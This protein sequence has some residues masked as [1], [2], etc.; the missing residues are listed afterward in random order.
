MQHIEQ[1]PEF[2]HNKAWGWKQGDIYYAEAHYLPGAGA[3]AT[4]AAEEAAG[5]VD[6]AR[7]WLRSLVETLP[8]SPGRDPGVEGVTDPLEAINRHDPSIKFKK[9]LDF[10]ETEF[11]LLNTTDPGKFMKWEISI[12]LECIAFIKEMDLIDLELK[13]TCGPKRKVIL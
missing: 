13:H 12:L 9:L 6:S 8:A 5:P 4:T 3:A 1:I 10:V 2:G 7:R 11:R